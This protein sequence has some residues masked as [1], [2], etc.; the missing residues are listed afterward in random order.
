MNVSEETRSILNTPAKCFSLAGLT[1]SGKLVDVSFTFNQFRDLT[2][3]VLPDHSGQWI[4]T[5]SESYSRYGIESDSAAVRFKK[6]TLIEMRQRP[7]Y[8]DC[9]YLEN[10][11]REF[12]NLSKFG[13]RENLFQMKKNFLE[14]VI[15]RLKKKMF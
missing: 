11:V 4:V 15:E 6:Q 13:G 9:I 5:P 12:E 10:R 7:V 14:G 3:S 1:E 2:E 8:T